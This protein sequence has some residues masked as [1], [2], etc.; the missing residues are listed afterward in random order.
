M[1]LKH[2]FVEKTMQ[3][4]LFENL[5]FKKKKSPKSSPLVKSIITSLMCDYQIL[6]LVCW[7]YIHTKLI[8]KL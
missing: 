4:S 6:R 8:E 3:I 5:A 7:S 2:I 1:Y